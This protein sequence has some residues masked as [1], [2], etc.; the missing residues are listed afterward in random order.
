MQ[1]NTQLARPVRRGRKVT[2]VRY[3]GTW[4]ERRCHAAISLHL[5]SWGSSPSFQAG[6]CTIR[7][8]LRV[9]APPSRLP[10]P[11]R[12]A[13]APE[14]ASFPLT[15]TQH[16]DS[17]A[18]NDDTLLFAVHISGPKRFFFRNGLHF[19]ACALQYRDRVRGVA[20]KAAQRD[21]TDHQ[22]SRL[23]GRLPTLCSSQH[24]YRTHCRDYNIAF[25]AF[26]LQDIN[27]T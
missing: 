16:R 14:L 9:I 11:T 7:R 15:S 26:C 12:N 23:L 3:L 19:Q 25:R 4:R 18:K 10:S 1:G 24:A 20:Y 17:T 2:R 27:R 8:T 5:P 13:C 6:L 21:L 22:L